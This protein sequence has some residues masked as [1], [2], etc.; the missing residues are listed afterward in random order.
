MDGANFC[1]ECGAKLADQKQDAPAVIETDV[2]VVSETVQPEELE[3][4]SQGSASNLNMDASAI[5]EEASIQT[6][7]SVQ[8]ET[9]AAEAGAKAEE[10]TAQDNHSD[11]ESDSG[12][13]SQSR[14]VASPEKQN[15]DKIWFYVDKDQSAGPFSVEEMM[16]KVEA[17][18]LNK[19]SYVWTKGLPE[20]IHLGQSDLKGILPVSQS[21]GS[22]SSSSFVK[23]EFERTAAGKNEN[24]AS[25][26]NAYTSQSASDSPLNLSK[27]ETDGAFVFDDNPSNG[28]NNASASYASNAAASNTAGQ[29]EASEEWFCVQDNHSTGPFSREMIR[30]MLANGTITPNTY[31]WKE[32]MSDWQFLESTALASLIGQSSYQNGANYQNQNQNPNTYNTYNT[33]NNYGNNYGQT[34][35]RNLTGYVP[36]R[37]IIL[38]ILLTV[39]TC[40][41]WEFIWYYQLAK[42]VNDLCVAQGKPKGCDPIL[43]VI[44]G[45]LTCNLYTIYFFWKDGKALSQLQYPNYRVDD[46]ATLLAIFAI[47]LPTVS[48]ALLQDQINSIVRYDKA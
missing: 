11:A 12:A 3:S 18:I 45:I 40:G 46:Q 16:D 48:C 36:K 8:P 32:G 21:A 19:N 34:N 1:I 42:D 41:I 20:W 23:E 44:L 28:Q 9:A 5:L 35:N 22:S 30:S 31:V 6:E 15:S 7:N 29:S 24:P 10:Q 27:T 17:G 14:T 26:F 47:F 39:L 13:F 43:A 33:Y 25:S 37:S 38:Y 2:T 4:S